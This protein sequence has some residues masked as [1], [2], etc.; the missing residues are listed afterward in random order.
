METEGKEGIIPQ[1]ELFTYRVLHLT[2]EKESLG[3]YQVLQQNP[4]MQWGRGF[5]PTVFNTLVTASE[6]TLEACKD[7]IQNLGALVW[8]PFLPA[9]PFLTP[10]NLGG[11]LILL[12]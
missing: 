2:L 3:N 12:T 8:P 4:L 11:L 5:L 7:L 1:T 10:A 9:L 6:A